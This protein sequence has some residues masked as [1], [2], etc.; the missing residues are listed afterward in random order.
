MKRIII[1]L[2]VLV[3]LSSRTFAQ[4][5]QGNW[6]LIF[7]GNLGSLESSTTVMGQTNSQSRTFANLSISPAYYIVDGLSI[8]PEFGLLAV[9]KQTPAQFILGNLS[10]THRLPQT[11]IALFLRAGYGV[12]NSIQ[13]PV[14]GGVAIRISEDFDVGVLN[15]GVGVKYIIKDIVALRSEVNYRNHS[16]TRESIGFYSPSYSQEN[17]YKHI[18]LLLGFSILL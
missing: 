15:I 16:W 8:E 9:E 4:F 10:Y 2:S 13:F 18:G 11:D 17:S 14:P 6:E 5:Q 1:A 7:S 12:S 3:I